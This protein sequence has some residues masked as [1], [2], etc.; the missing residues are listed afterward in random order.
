MQVILLLIDRSFRNVW[1]VELSMT[2]LRL[3]S[4]SGGVS[5]RHSSCHT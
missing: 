1:A 5:S 4:V 2:D 3:M